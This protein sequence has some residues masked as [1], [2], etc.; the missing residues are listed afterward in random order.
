[1]QIKEGGREKVAFVYGN[2]KKFYLPAGDYIAV[3]A[4]KVG[5][6]KELSETEFIVEAGKFQKVELK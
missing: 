1:M 3:F 6:E 5:G 2:K 4:H